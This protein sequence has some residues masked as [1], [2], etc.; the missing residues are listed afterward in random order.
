VR[1]LDPAAQ[2]ALDLMVQTHRRLTS[3][4]A[5]VAVSGV[6][7]R[8]REASIGVVVLERGSRC[9]RIEVT[10][11]N[12]SKLLSATDG[13]ERLYLAS[14][15]NANRRLAAEPGEKVLA[16]TIAESNLFVA[17]VFGFLL[18]KESAIKELIPPPITVITRATEASVDGVSC[19]VIACETRAEGKRSRILFSIGKSDHLLRQLV[20]ETNQDGVLFTLTELYTSVRAN[21]KLP[22]SA[23]LLPKK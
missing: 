6:T 18:T 23:F 11:A 13:K 17:P 4:Q 2:K 22:K 1:Q 19:D 14:Q 10:R 5:T 7:E 20:I 12:Q 8:R 3:Y 21:P 9:A 15:S 16:A